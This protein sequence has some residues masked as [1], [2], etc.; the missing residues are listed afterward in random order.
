M[1]DHLSEATVV[2]TLE[3]SRTITEAAARLGCARNNLYQRAQRSLSIMSALDKLRAK[4]ARPVRKCL[5]CPEP[6]GREDHQFCS[7]ACYWRWRRGHAD[8]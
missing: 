1:S 4:K 8:A 5:I 6:V 2:A 7:P 3:D